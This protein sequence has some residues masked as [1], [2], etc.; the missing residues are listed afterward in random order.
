MYVLRAHEICIKILLT[1][2]WHF[3]SCVRR[4]IIPSCSRRN[5]LEFQLRT[6]HCSLHAKSVSMVILLIITENSSLVLDGFVC[7]AS[8][9]RIMEVFFFGK[10]F[11]SHLV[12]HLSIINECWW[13]KH[14][15]NNFNALNGFSVIWLIFE[16]FSMPFTIISLFVLGA[17]YEN[18]STA[19]GA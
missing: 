17:Q 16:Y 2:C 3:A 12:N 13:K 10:Q 7:V 4:P 11:F 14:A 18:M 5:H 15:D 8:G 19:F 6:T 1:D 9:R